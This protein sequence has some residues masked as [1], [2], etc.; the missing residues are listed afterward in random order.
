[1][2]GRHGRR[3]KLLLDGARERRRKKYRGKTLCSPSRR[4]AMAKA[5]ARDSKQLRLYVTLATLG[6]HPISRRRQDAR[7]D[8]KTLGVTKSRSAQLGV[9]R[10]AGLSRF[11]VVERS[12]S[13]TPVFS[14][15]ATSISSFSFGATLRH[16]ISR[17]TPCLAVG[18]TCGCV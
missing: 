17:Y 5:R 14:L 3:R 16:I 2:H 4:T 6:D 10:L 7:V 9:R 12:L 13:L 8:R 18:M 1:M 11:H 15:K